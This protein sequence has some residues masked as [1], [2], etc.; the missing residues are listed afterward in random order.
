MSGV[1]LDENGF[2]RREGNLARVPPLFAPVVAAAKTGI[3]AAFGPDVLHSA[4]LYGSIP[5]GT[6]VAG[7]SDLDVFLVLRDEPAAAD[8]AA[9]AGLERSLDA[10]FPEINGAGIGLSSVATVLSELERHDLGWFVACLCTPLTG[11]DLAARLPRYRPTPLLARETNGDIVDRLPRWRELLGNAETDTDLRSLS[12]LAS[13][14]IVRSGFTL[15][16]PRWG[17]WTSHLDE[18]A[19]AFGQYYPRRAEQMRVAASVSHAPTADRL[20]LTMLIND[21]GPWLAGEYLAVHGQKTP[22]PQPE[23]PQP[24]TSSPP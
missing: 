20:V 9:A 13:R 1:G 14:G 18:M 11:E 7:L 16:M 4:Y 12:R 6:A 15:V 10:R 2:I 19:A 8:R 24:E 21:L 23:R 5:R 3:L 22:R 17:G